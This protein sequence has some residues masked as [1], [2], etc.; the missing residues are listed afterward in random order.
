MI[1]VTV[2]TEDE[3][4][5]ALPENCG[6]HKPSPIRM[7]KFLGFGSTLWAALSS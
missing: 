1:Q 6:G 3:L 2:I 4:S 5:S 7:E